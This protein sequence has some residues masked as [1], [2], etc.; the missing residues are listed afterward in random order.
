M[1]SCHLAPTPSNADS[2]LATKCQDLGNNTNAW[3]SRSGRC[4]FISLDH[5]GPDNQH[6]L[7]NQIVF[8]F[9]VNHIITKTIVG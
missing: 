1:L 8:A 3:F 6:R 4:S 9:Q 5:Y 7:A 2:I